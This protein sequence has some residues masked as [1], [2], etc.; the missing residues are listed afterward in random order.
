MSSQMRAV[1]IVRPG[2]PEVLEIKTRTIPS[3]SLRQILI[4]VE[5][6]GINRPDVLQRE[7][8]YPPPPGASDIPGLEVAGTVAACGDDVHAYVEGDKVMALVPGGGYAEY[9]AVD[10][11]H[12]I[13]VPGSLTVTEAAAVPETFFTVWHNVFDRGALKKGERF[14]VHGGSS[15]IGTT[16]IQLAREFGAEVFAT[17]GSAEKCQSCLDLG[18]AHAINYRE[19]DFVTVIGDRTGKSGVDLILDMVG[20]DYIGRNYQAA[21]MDGRIVQIAFLGGAVTEANFANL[22]MKRLVHTGSTLRARSDDFKADLANALRLHVLPLLDERKV[23]PVMDTI[24][25]FSQIQAA[26]Q[27]MDEGQHIGK[28]V[29]QMD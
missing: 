19:E 15:G 18:A 27:R 13:P 12:A 14:L 17:A 10:E 11:R 16:A 3:P 28:I 4:K 6:A 23:F 2:G 21:A 9:V 29:V 22:M 25:P 1:E 20:G 8:K 7:G 24:F 26:H 5:A